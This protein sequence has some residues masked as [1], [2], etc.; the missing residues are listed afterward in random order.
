M[1]SDLRIY[2][3]AEEHSHFKCE[4]RLRGCSFLFLSLS[5]VK[6]THTHG[7]VVGALVL[8]SASECRTVVPNIFPWNVKEVDIHLVGGYIEFS[9]Q[10]CQVRHDLFVVF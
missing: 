10:L 3:D 9:K 1:A 7:K 6:L 4:Q 5:L 2:M 8:F